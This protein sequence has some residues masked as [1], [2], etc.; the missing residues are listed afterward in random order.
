MTAVILLACAL[1]CAL[2]MIPLGL[3]GTWTMVA[4][5]L[6][7]RLAVPAGGIQFAT[8]AEIA[9]LAMAAEL[10]ELSVTARFARRYGGSRRAAWGAVIGGFVGVIV[11]VPLPIIGPVIA[12]LLG[13]FLGALIGELESGA[14][15]VAAARAA[16]GAL[17]GRVAA[18]VM[19]VA[20]GVAIAA[21]LVVAA[22]R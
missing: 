11:G 2:L 3:P 13:T 5:G 16:M 7:Y 18:S 22:I 20:V 10:L 14:H 12:G 19:K 8:V 4:I 1:L 21:W 15:H 17:L 9:A 6:V